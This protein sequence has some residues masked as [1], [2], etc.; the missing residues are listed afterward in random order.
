MAIRASLQDTLENGQPADRAITERLAKAVITDPEERFAARRHLMS[1]LAVKAKLDWWLKKAGLQPS[2]GARLAAN[3]MFRFDARADVG[4]RRWFD[5]PEAREAEKTARALRPFEGKPFLHA[6][7]DELTQ[8]ECPAQLEA[9]LR[10]AFGKEFKA[11]LGGLNRFAN[12]TLRVNTLKADIKTVAEALSREEIIAQPTALS[13]LGLTV[14]R[15]GDAASSASFTSGLVE[16]QDEGSQLAALL[17]DA[18]S[19]QRVLDLCAGAGGKTLALSA[20]MKNKGHLI[21]CDV[22]AKRLQR[23][24]VRFRRAGANNI[25]IRALD[26]EGRKWL[27]RQAGRFDRVLIDA[28]CTGTG[29]WRRNPDSRWHLA[30]EE[31]PNLVKLQD[32]LLDQA[33]RLVK[34]GGKLV[35][36]T[37]SVLLEENDDR[38]TAFLE[39][40]PEY[41]LQP[42]AE[43]WSKI[44]FAPY[45]GGKEP[46]LHLTPAK[47]GTD[48]FS[49]A[50]LVRRTSVTDHPQT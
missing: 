33:A 49:V 32:E 10:R 8:L 17:V 4:A 46:I 1:A 3:E 23:A 48:G 36:A 29:S 44:S 12:T 45:P 41:E 16:A 35:Y 15:D 18:Q 14:K 31:L 25:E 5:K 43:V 22:S 42:A 27:K 21:A 6:Q 2:A 20:Q 39:R 28:P 13:P 7:M 38:V 24:K 47:H 40:H 26:P 19:G 34:L 37:C 9:P 30:K 50:I 11:E